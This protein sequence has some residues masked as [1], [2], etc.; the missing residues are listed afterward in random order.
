MNVDKSLVFVLG[1]QFVLPFLQ[2]TVTVDA[3]QLGWEEVVLGMTAKGTWSSI[4]L[5]C[6]L[7]FWS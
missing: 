6:T 2:A 5:H 7:V 4:W 1:S 3:S